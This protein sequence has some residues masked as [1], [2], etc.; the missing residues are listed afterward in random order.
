MV[1]SCAIAL[2]VGHVYY[3]NP[4]GMED[5]G[6]AACSGQVRASLSAAVD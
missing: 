6:Y 5:S 1:A 3:V 4:R 2:Q